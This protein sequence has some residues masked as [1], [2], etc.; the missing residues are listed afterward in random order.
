MQMEIAG[1]AREMSSEVGYLRAEALFASSLQRSDHPTPGQ[2]RAAVAASLHR[3]GPGECA[4]HLAQEY[5]DHPA[6][7]A[8]RMSWALTQVA[9]RAT[10]RRARI[11]NDRRRRNRIVEGRG[12]TNHSPLW[13]D[14]DPIKPRRDSAVN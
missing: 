11:H 1:Q 4:S 10:R 14:E 12:P 8:M 3:F 7:A 2:V 9:S 5:G 6:E 13:A